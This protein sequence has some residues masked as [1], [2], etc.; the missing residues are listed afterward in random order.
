MGRGARAHQTVAAMTRRV[1]LSDEAERDL[2]EAARW[3]EEQRPGLGDEYI[4]EV[5]AAIERLGTEAMMYAPVYHDARRIP[6]RR[7]PYMIY[8]VVEERFIRVIS[9]F[10]GRRDPRR[11]RE[12]L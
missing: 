10:H 9:V 6:V 7:F 5:D 8:Y 12:R 4:R 3:Y 1:I 11:W 2:L